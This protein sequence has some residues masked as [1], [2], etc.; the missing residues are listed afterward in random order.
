MTIE[1]EFIIER[2]HEGDP[3]P[4]ARFVRLVSRL[5]CDVTV[6]QQGREVDGTNVMAL[7]ELSAAQ[8]SHV[9]IRVEGRDAAK[10]V[11]KIDQFLKSF[12][13]ES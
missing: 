8:G 13:R 1:R 4:A 11:R 9:H 5:K 7:L 6:A 12:D 2:N 3:W 10:A